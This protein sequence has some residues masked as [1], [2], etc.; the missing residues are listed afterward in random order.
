M[1]NELGQLVV[2]Y[3]YDPTDRL[4]RK[5]LGNGLFTTYE[6][7]AAGQLLNLTNCLV[8][9]TVLSRFNYAYDTRGRRTAMDTLDG[10]WTYDYDDLGQLTHAVFASTAPDVPSQDL[11]YAYD[12]L[13]SPIRTIENG[14]TTAYTANNLNQ[15]VRVGNTNY[16]FDLDGNLIQEI[17]PTGTNTFTYNDENRLV[18]VASP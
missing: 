3:S 7:D 6:Y 8:N 1:T 11:A 17:A 4:A 2:L 18:G 12:A 16:V 13:G 10:R 9:G 5:T 14:V 15:Y